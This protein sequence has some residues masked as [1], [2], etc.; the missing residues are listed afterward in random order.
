MQPSKD[1]VIFKRITS[2]G[3]KK[4]EQHIYQIVTRKGIFH[5][6]HMEAL[7]LLKQLNQTFEEKHNETRN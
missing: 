6:N 5:I 1:Q 2:K 3:L 4:L 7:S